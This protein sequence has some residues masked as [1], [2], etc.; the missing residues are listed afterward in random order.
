MPLA[1][2]PFYSVTYTAVQSLSAAIITDVEFDA[3]STLFSIQAQDW[4]VFGW[5]ELVLGGSGRS[6]GVF[7]AVSAL[8]LHTRRH[9]AADHGTTVPA[10]ERCQTSVTRVHWGPVG[11]SRQQPR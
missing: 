1:Q 6:P 5:S 3:S 8:V 4:T 11:S 7:S 2:F 10:M 9:M